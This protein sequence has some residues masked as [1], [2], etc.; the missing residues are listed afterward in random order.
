MNIKDGTCCSATQGFIV[1]RICGK[2]VCFILWH[3]IGTFYALRY[4]DGSICQ[5]FHHIFIV[6]Q[7]FFDNGILMLCIFTPFYFQ[8]L[9]WVFV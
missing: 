3:A 4:P 8:Y 7:E 9:A 5:G 6:I 1:I 2:A